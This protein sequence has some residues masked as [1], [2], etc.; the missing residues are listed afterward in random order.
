MHIHTEVV[1]LGV[2]LVQ[3]VIALGRLIFYPK[4][5][6]AK[7]PKGFRGFAITASMLSLLA[8]V[9]LLARR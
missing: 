5:P 1:L 8:I 6:I 4:V 9:A 7:I 3:L 2:F